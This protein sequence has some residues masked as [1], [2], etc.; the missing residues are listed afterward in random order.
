[1]SRYPLIL[2][3]ACAATLAT[4]CGES[5]PTETTNPEPD[6]GGASVSSGA[7]CAEDPCG[8]NAVC[9]GGEQAVCV[10]DP[11]YAGDSC[12]DCAPG[13]ARTEAEACAQRLSET[14]VLPA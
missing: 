6:A 9:V 8:D 1:M 2:P 13:F 5:E 10:C 3:L 12:D 7:A 14:A 11:G 4:A